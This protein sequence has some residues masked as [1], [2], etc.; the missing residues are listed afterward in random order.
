ME[1]REVTAD[2]WRAVVRTEPRADQRQFVAH[3][4]YYLNLC[5]YG[6]VWRPVAIYEDGEPFGFAM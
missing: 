3:V 6:G 1:L 5:H 2:N 4:S